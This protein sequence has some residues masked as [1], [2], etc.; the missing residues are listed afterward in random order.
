MKIKIPCKY[1]IC[2]VLATG[3]V[4]FFIERRDNVPIFTLDI[5]RAAFFA[6]KKLAEREEVPNAAIVNIEKILRAK[7]ELNHG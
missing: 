6:S 5:N 7:A 1:L 4:A 3:K 2:S